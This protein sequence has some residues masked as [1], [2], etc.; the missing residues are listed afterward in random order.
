MM[1]STKH[2][3]RKQTIVIIL[4]RLHKGRRQTR[5]ASKRDQLAETTNVIETR[6]SRKHDRMN[7]VKQTI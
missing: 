5:S 7:N 4:A 6:T 2:S 3:E 1:A